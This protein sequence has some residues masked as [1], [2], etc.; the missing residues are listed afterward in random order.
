MNTE[1]ILNF[2]ETYSQSDKL[3]VNEII[4]SAQ[5]NSM[6]YDGDFKA[7]WLLSQ[8]DEPVWETR[9]KGREK[10]VNGKWINTVKIK[11]DINII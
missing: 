10:V 11:W 7:R 1:N 5:E 8:F 4:A 6:V 2:P 9:N 3:L